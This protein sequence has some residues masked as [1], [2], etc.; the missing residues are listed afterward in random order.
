GRVLGHVKEISIVDGTGRIVASSDAALVGQPLAAAGALPATVGER[1]LAG[2]TDLLNNSAID[3]TTEAPSGAYPLY[4]SNDRV[5]GAV[6]VEKFERTY[7]PGLP[8]WVLV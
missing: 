5:I 2:S 8:L 3:R 4:G 1:A 6:V 7:K